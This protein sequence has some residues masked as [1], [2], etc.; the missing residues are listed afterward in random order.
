GLTVTGRGV[1]FGSVLEAIAQQANLIS[2]PDGN[3]TEWARGEPR[4][5]LGVS[6]AASPGVILRARPM[7]EV[8]G[9]R[10]ELLETIGSWSLDWGEPPTVRTTGLLSEMNGY[11]AGISGPPADR[12]T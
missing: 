7:L 4:S 8:N 10:Q 3:W 1:S 2:A 5:G 6:P 9:Q 11:R 12:T